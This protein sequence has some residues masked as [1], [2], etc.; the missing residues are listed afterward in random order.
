MS[1]SEYSSTTRTAETL[2]RGNIITLQRSHIS[3]SHHSAIEINTLH[4]QQGSASVV[5]TSDPTPTSDIMSLLYGINKSLRGS[6]SENVSMQEEAGRRHL[7]PVS[8]SEQDL[9]LE[10]KDPRPLLPEICMRK[11]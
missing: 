8:I 3:E 11:P 7:K 10:R 4:H 2:E 1:K 5:D 9:E 6:Q